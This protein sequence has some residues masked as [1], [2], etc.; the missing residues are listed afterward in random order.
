MSWWKMK[1][2][3]L[4]AQIHHIM[5]FICVSI[6]FEYLH[7]FNLFSK[8]PAYLN[9]HNWTNTAHTIQSVKANTAQD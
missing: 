9:L 6:V 5:H 3:K 4:R 7:L 2:R 8:N 1:P